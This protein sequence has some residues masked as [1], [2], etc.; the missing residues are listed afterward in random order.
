MIRPPHLLVALALTSCVFDPSGVPIRVLD[1][2]TAALPDG[3]G[4]GLEPPSADLADAEVADAMPPDHAAGLEVGPCVPVSRKLQL[5]GTVVGGPHVNFPLL[6]SLS[7]GWLKTQ[8]AGGRVAHPAGF[9][10]AFTA[11]AAG[12]Q[13]LDHEIERY[14]GTSG[15]LAAWVRIP[16]LSASTT[17]YLRY[18]DCAVTSSQE[19]PTAVWDASF[20]AVWH[21]AEAVTDE[22][23]TGQHNDSTANKIACSQS[24]NG[25]VLG[26]VGGAQHFD[27]DDYIS[28]AVGKIQDTSSFTISA[29]VNLDR[30]TAAGDPFYGVLVN[31]A[32]AAPYKGY[33]LYVERSNGKFGHYVDSTWKLSSSLIVPDKQWA[34]VAIRGHRHPTQGTLEVSINGSPWETVFTG[35]TSDLTIVGTPPL[36]IG[37][38]ETTQAHMLQGTVDELRFADVERGYGWLAT[39]TANHSDPAGFLAVGPE[40]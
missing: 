20:G 37:A 36:T 11:D 1:P 31:V 6:V 17:L 8:A 29:W 15:A 35:S 2:E 13:K 21:L 5:A 18:G 24:N 25:A 32:T 38:Y 10:I 34:Y 3:P 19:K 40:Q 12:T 14:D 26:R 27:G 7:A 33:A 22:T 39:E 4:V 28:C 23:T 30:S 16:S 9:D